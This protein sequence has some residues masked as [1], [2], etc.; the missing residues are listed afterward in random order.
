M[1]LSLFAFFLKLGFISFGGGYTMISFIL[2]EGQVAVGLTA[3]EFSDMAALELLASGP[4]AVNSAT[5]IGFIKAGFS[6]AVIATAAVCLPSFILTAILYAFLKRFSENKYVQSA[7]SAIVIACGGALI[8]A[9]GTLIQN[10]LLYTDNLE[11]VIRHPADNIFWAGCLI[12]VICVVAIKKF[13]ISPIVMLL[14]SAVLG[15][16][17]R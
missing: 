15:A 17:L 6:G 12:V 9:A 1:L 7:I 8:A 11:E 10:I 16:I 3:Q 4:I 2:Q 14:V 5:Y 13:K